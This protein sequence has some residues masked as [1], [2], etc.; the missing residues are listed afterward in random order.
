M[1]QSR[2]SIECHNYLFPSILLFAMASLSSGGSVVLVGTEYPLNFGALDVTELN[3]KDWK[4]CLIIGGIL[5][6]TTSD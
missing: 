3:G 2:R 1:Y 6:D 4:S 5:N